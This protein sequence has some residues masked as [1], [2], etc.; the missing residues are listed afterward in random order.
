MDYEDLTDMENVLENLIHAMEEAEKFAEL[1]DIDLPGARAKLRD[2]QK[3]LDRFD[4]EYT[5]AMCRE[6]ERCAM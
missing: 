6:Y 1:D 4:A 5:A 2:V 3:R